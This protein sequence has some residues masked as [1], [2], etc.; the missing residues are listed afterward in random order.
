MSKRGQITDYAG[1]EIYAGDL[2][3]Y[4]AR[5]GNMVRMTDALVLKATGKLVGGKVRPML[6]VQPTGDES[7]FV[8]RKTLRSEWI[9]VDHVRLI[10]PGGDA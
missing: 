3:A 2:V 1:D 6:K 4:A 5:R 8:K 10:T 9:E 7:G